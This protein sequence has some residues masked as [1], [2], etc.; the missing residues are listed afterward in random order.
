MGSAGSPQ[1]KAVLCPTLMSAASR[2]PTDA[3]ILELLMLEL[4]DAGGY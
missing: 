2:V 4:L 1:L 3:V